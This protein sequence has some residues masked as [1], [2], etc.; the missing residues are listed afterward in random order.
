LLLAPAALKWLEILER[1]ASRFALRYGAALYVTIKGD[2]NFDVVVVGA[3][4]AGSS[5]ALVL[6][7]A[8]FRVALLEKA[9]LPRYKTCG[10]GLLGRAL[11]LLPFEVG[12]VVERECFGA[13]L[14][15]HDPTLQFSTHRNRPVVTMVMRDQFDHLL[16]TSAQNAGVQ[17]ISGVALLDLKEDVD[18]IELRTT[19]GVFKARFVIGADGAQSVVARKCGLPDLRHVIPAIESEVTVDEAQFDRFRDE[20]RFD[21]G[22]TPYGYGWVFSKREHLSVG[23]LTTRRGSCNLNDEYARYL[24]K[25]GLSPIKEERHGYMIPLSPREKLVGGRRVLLVGDAAGFADPVTAEGISNAISSG[26]LAAEAIVNE[27]MNE[28]AVSRQYLDR[29]QTTLLP[30]LRVA[31]VLACVLYD[32]PRVRSSLFARHG[33]RLSDLLTRIVMGEVTYSEAVSRPKNYL[34]LLF[35]GA[36]AKAVGA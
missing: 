3:G 12:P 17:L 26:R 13:E 19:G 7:E 36:F 32:F 4:P 15:H 29:L 6:A 8:G 10:G 23:V 1:R 5:A 11:K 25:I 24:A 22:L 33:Q 18:S 2:M 31:R 20:A 30:E 28:T 21:F 16:T 34:E 27:G 35:P 9:L 14:H